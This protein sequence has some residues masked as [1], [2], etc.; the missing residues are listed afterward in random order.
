VIGHIIFKVL[1]FISRAIFFIAYIFRA[2]FLILP[3]DVEVLR[4]RSDDQHVTDYTSPIKISFVD[5]ATVNAIY[6]ATDLELLDLMEEKLVLCGYDKEDIIKT[7]S[8]LYVPGDEEIAVLAHVDTVFFRKPDRITVINGVWSASFDACNQWDGLG[9]DDRSGIYIIWRLLDLGHRP[10][11]I[12]LNHE[13]SG[14]YGAREFVKDVKECPGIKYMVE[15]DR[16]GGDEAVYYGCANKKFEK[17]VT[18]HGFKKNI[19]MFSD[20]GVIAPA[21]GVAAAN[22]S[23]GVHEEHTVNE[24]VVVVEVESVIKKADE[25]LRHV[26]RKPFTYKQD[27]DYVPFFIDF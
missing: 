14:C 17:F 27:K 20:I 18:R 12:L 11:V 6:K 23:I 10:H 2:I 1:V 24:R 3:V 4:M 15:F 9:G 21:W 16:H 7:G 5:D 25:M 22:L 19:G 26:P 8:Y 13:E